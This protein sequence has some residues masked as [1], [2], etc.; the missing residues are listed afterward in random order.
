LRRVRGT[1]RR[2]ESP[3]DS[4]APH[5]TASAIRLTTHI[6]YGMTSN[7]TGLLVMAVSIDAP[8]KRVHA[9]CIHQ[10]AIPDTG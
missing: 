2:A 6:Q 4:T 7:M 3:N 5:I 1:A 10:N 9:L 8:A